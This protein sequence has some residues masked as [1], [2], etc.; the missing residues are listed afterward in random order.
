MLSTSGRFSRRRFE[1]INCGSPS[2]IVLASVAVNSLRNHLFLC[3]LIL[4][5]IST[6]CS[7]GAT[8]E[9]TE[10]SFSQVV[11]VRIGPM[12]PYHAKLATVTLDELGSNPGFTAHQESFDCVVVDR[13]QTRVTV[14]ELI[15][16]GL[17]TTVSV[18]T[19][20]RALDN[21]TWI[22]LV[23]FEGSAEQSHSLLP[24][25]QDVSEVE[26][27]ALESALLA[28]A[29]SMTL[30]IGAEVSKAVESLEVELELAF[31]FSTDS[32]ACVE[33]SSPSASPQGASTGDASL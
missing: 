23:G 16:A 3:L 26:E 33:R 7:N 25:V 9:R 32:T 18:T 11:Q 28:N 24:T 17:N 2:L 14:T 15:S 13:E 12:D 21:P 29:P 1:T 6:G 20:F 8:D 30:R 22:R 4:V 19:S 10:M 31:F 5:P 27:R